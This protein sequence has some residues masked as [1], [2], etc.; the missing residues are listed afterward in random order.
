M[1]A[2]CLNSFILLSSSFLSSLERLGGAGTVLETNGTTKH[3]PHD[4][5]GI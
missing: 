3:K 1:S 4:A 2:D 5:L